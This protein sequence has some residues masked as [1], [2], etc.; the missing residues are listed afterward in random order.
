MDLKLIFLML[1][2]LFFIP[3]P[4]IPYLNLLSLKIC[5]MFPPL[6]R[7]FLVCLNLLKTMMYS[8]N[9]TLCLVL[10]RIS[11]PSKSSSRVS[12][13]KVSIVSLFTSLHSLSTHTPSLLSPMLLT[14]A[15]VAYPLCSSVVPSTSSKVFPVSSLELWHKRLG[16]CAF[17]V[18]E[19]ALKSCNIHFNSIKSSL[20][21]HPC[22]IAKSHRLPYSPSSSTCTAPLSI[23]HS[24]LWGPSPILS[25]NGFSYYVTFID[26][27]SRF[28]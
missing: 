11:Q 4:R 9:F 6:Q 10:W 15:P 25:R 19:K 17:D 16:H 1:D 20:L 18:V 7:T 21:C 26:E 13:I 12:L 22:C 23:I 3:L 8:L 28:T 14:K 2:I 24:D 27:Y 5:Y